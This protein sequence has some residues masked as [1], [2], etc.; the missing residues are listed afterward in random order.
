M[1]CDS[2]SSENTLAD[3]QR[4][5]RQTRAYWVVFW[6]LL[7]LAPANADFNAGMQASP[8]PS[9]GD[10]SLSWNEPSPGYTS[11]QERIDGGAW[12]T[13]VGYAYLEMPTDLQDKPAGSYD[14]RLKWTHQDCSSGGGGRCP[15]VTEYSLPT[16]VQVEPPGPPP[17][18]PDDYSDQLQYEYQIRTGDFDTNGYTDILIDRLTAGEIDGSMQTVILEGGSTGLTINVPTQ[19]ELSTARTFP[20]NQDLELG[21]TDKNY[22]GF[23][24]LMLYGLLLLNESPLSEYD[25]IVLYASGVP[26]V[27]EPQGWTYL[28]EEFTE[29]F[30]N[31]AEAE[32]NP[33]FYAENLQV[34]LRPVFEHLVNCPVQ[35]YPF[36]LYSLWNCR[37]EI[38]FVG[39]EIQ[40]VGA[41]FHPSAPA[42]T[43]AIYRIKNGDW[44][45]GDPWWDLSQAMYS[46][47]GVHSF[48]F[49]A[50]GTRVSTNYSTSVEGDEWHQLFSIYNFDL[51]G[52]YYESLAAQAP[53]DWPRHEYDVA[54]TICSTSSTTIVT[55]PTLPPNIGDVGAIPAQICTVENVFCWA[56]RRPAPRQD[57]SEA[58]VVDGEASVLIGNNPIRTFIFDNSS[59]LVNQT[60][61][62]GVIPGVGSH[63][64]HDSQSIDLCADSDSYGM[65]NANSPRCSYVHRQVQS[66]SGNIVVRTHGEGHNPNANAVVLNEIVGQSIFSEVDQWI[67]MQM[68]MHG[69]CSDD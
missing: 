58:T 32:I 7:P 29:F 17:S 37:I 64:L 1:P 66:E 21:G 31:V 43:G 44:S 67:R 22:D 52:Y 38:V 59:T 36:S 62:E 61:P 50:D 26:G 53:E 2:Q 69:S 68:A 5:I 14:Y 11:L 4:Q 33:N 57:Q 24:D 15:M 3:R 18:E 41:G 63:V 13:I 10:F 39:F 60:L 16:N 56:K 48:G 20:V 65:I 6:L 12:T 25:T 46:V 51:L 8:N 27:A 35:F 9:T 30:G 19:Q 23:S 40:S 45:G 55:D 42:A 34:S 28:D 54:T 47:L 49:R